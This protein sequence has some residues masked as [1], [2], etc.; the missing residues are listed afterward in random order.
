MP[1]LPGKPVSLHKNAFITYWKDLDYYQAR[2]LLQPGQASITKT[3]AMQATP[4]KLCL[5]GS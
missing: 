3:A 4:L 1:F 2:P 5:D